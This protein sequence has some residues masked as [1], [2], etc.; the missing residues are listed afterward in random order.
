MNNTLSG[1][2]CIIQSRVVLQLNNW[3]GVLLT[4]YSLPTPFWQNVQPF[5]VFHRVQP[6]KAAPA[7]I[8]SA[9]STHLFFCRLLSM[10]YKI[11][12]FPYM[13]F[14][15]ASCVKRRF[16]HPRFNLC[17]L[18]VSSMPIFPSFKNCCKV[19]SSNFTFGSE[20]WRC[21]KNTDTP[22]SFT[23]YWIF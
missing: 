15:C 3:N 14:W 21:K 7:I 1:V 19:L 16:P 6:T 4:S 5:F 11:S 20:S 10:W 2:I 17:F 18:L 12:L 8:F 9:L 13:F 22:F 23:K